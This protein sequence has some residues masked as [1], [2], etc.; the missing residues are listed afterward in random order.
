MLIPFNC[1][2]KEYIK[3]I[4][5]GD[6]LYKITLSISKSSKILIT[7]NTKDDVLS[8]YEYSIELSFEEFYKLG[9]CFKQCNSIEEIY[10]LLKNVMTEIEISSKNNYSLNLK[11]KIKLE[12]LKDNGL[13]LILDIP[14]LTG[15]IEKIKIEFSTFK[16][17]PIIQFEKIK[18]KYKYLTK[19]IYDRK[20]FH[21]IE[22]S[23]TKF[24]ENLIKKIEEKKEPQ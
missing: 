13:A 9:K 22:K 11:S 20:G 14:L 3:E 6:D 5:F 7:C 24:L 21:S 17:D 19:K 8:L 15:N 18:E 12:N 16:K 23:E 4:N 2:K 1:D 10:D